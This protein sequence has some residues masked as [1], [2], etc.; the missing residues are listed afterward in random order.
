MCRLDHI[1]SLAPQPRQVPM[2]DKNYSSPC[3]RH[4]VCKHNRGQYLRSG[5]TQNNPTKLLNVSS[6]NGV[7][8]I[9]HIKLYVAESG[10]EDVGLLTD[11][12]HVNPDANRI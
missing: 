12:S 2:F 6:H 7:P 4:L 11:F 1:T 10:V 5:T 8:K 9:F 3:K